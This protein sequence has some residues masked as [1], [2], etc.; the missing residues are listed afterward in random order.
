[1]APRFSGHVVLVTGGG[2][3]IGRAMAERFA[4][5]GAKVAVADLNDETAEETAVAIVEKGGAA[6][7]VQ[8]DVRDEASVRKMTNAV[9]EKA[10]PPSVL[11]NCAGIGTTLPLLETDL[12]TWNQTIAVN[13]T[14]SFL[15]AKAVLPGMVD[16]GFG[17]IVL[18]GSINSRKALKHRNAYAVSKAGVASLAQLLAVEF[19]EH[20]ITANCIL[21]G[22]VNTA[23][24]RRMHDQTIR[25]AYHARLPIKRY[26]QPEEIA[27]AAAFLASDEAAYITG[28][29][30]DV[31]GGFDV[32]GL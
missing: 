26:G 6:V 7:S 16:A 8:V 4:D 23:L 13:L 24:T 21:P 28:H 30:L 10:G 11:V 15:V 22:P 32:S 5:E 2:S 20:G 29:L 17:R 19:A 18:I 3:G 9:E 25:D 27:A 1:M 12:A 31:D 14:G